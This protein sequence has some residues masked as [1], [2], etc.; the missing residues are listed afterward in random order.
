[1][2][3]ELPLGR[4]WSWC[5]WVALPCLF[6]YA[7][8]PEGPLLLLLLSL[9]IVVIIA[10]P[11]LGLALYG[12]AATSGNFFDL[13]VLQG[14]SLARVFGL[15]YVFGVVVAVLTRRRVANPRTLATALP[16][17]AVLAAVN[18]A[19]VTYSLAPSASVDASLTMLLN[20]LVFLATLALPAEEE[21]TVA[22]DLGSILTFCLL[23]FAGSAFV[24]GGLA[25][26][27][28]RRLSPAEA[29]NANE[30]GVALAQLACLPL[31]SLL[32]PKAAPGPKLLAVL[33]LGLALPMLFLSGSRSSLLGLA[34]GL[35]FFL[36]VAGEG[37]LAATVRRAGLA[38]ALLL[39]ALAAAFWLSPVV[40]SRFTVAAVTAGQGAG[41]LEIW[42]YLLANV[43]PRR[44][45]F[46]TGL[47]GQ[48]VVAALATAPILHHEPAHN[49]L[50]DLLTQLGLVGLAGYMVFFAWL[51]RRGIAAARGSD[52]ARPWLAMLAVSLAIGVGETMFQDKLLWLAGAVCLRYGR[53]S[54]R[55][56][57][58]R[59][60]V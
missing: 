37:T 59:E 48:S 43:V 58:I 9:G 18:L 57:E 25:A 42:R 32:A 50:L 11:L 8:R 38:L 4:L 28:S 34:V 20:F 27:A 3:S 7:L 54:R 2:R 53:A 6:A 22:R 39:L 33:A 21:S 15:L 12:V 24:T 29:V 60:E 45:A 23:L 35:I 56:P 40:M 46:G 1:M 36:G 31:W 47:G 14:V 19:S 16:L 52:L 49:I 30:F 26:V 44:L 5:A 55:R 51:V 17:L 41:R 13:A 10:R